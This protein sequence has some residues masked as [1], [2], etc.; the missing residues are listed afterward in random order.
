[1]ILTTLVCANSARIKFAFDGLRCLCEEAEIFS[2]LSL[3]FL[4]SNINTFNQ[5]IR[6]FSDKIEELDADSDLF[7]FIRSLDASSSG[8]HTTWELL[9]QLWIRTFEAPGSASAEK[10][11]TLWGIDE[12]TSV[13]RFLCSLCDTLQAKGRQITSL[14]MEEVEGI[15]AIPS[16]PLVTQKSSGAILASKF[17]TRVY[18]VLSQSSP[19]YEIHRD[20]LC[21]CLANDLHPVMFASFLEQGVAKLDGIVT[22]SSRELNDAKKGQN[23]NLA[24][25]L[26]KISSAIF[27]RLAKTNPQIL[28]S[29]DVYP[30]LKNIKLI[31]QTIGEGADT[32]L[33]LKIE[34]CRLITQ[35]MEIRQ[36]IIFSKEFLFRNRLLDS[37]ISWIQI[38]D[39]ETLKKDLL[40][41]FQ[42]NLDSFSLQACASVLRGLPIVLESDVAATVIML[43]FYVFI[44]LTRLLG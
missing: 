25:R 17:L 33:G 5:M 8:V 6:V 32:G 10:A 2:D 14:S 11:S 40:N 35:I 4:S 26:A 42:S 7:T 39:E 36:L 44:L 28:A 23:V 21:D 38:R 31:I 18:D 43:A 24:T 15:D 12:W 30:T 13:S 20:K 22:T 19:E 27:S 34:F 16:N 9:F 1:M 29:I 37:F 3:G 41:D